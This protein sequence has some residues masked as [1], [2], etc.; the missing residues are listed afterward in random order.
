MN[1]QNK[2]N[3]QTALSLLFW[4]IFAAVAEPCFILMP[5]N[6]AY[7][8]EP[9]PSVP[10]FMLWVV[11]VMN[12]PKPIPTGLGL[13]GTGFL[14]GLAEPKLCWLLSLATQLPLT[15]GFLLVMVWGALRGQ[16]VSQTPIL[17]VRFH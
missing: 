13:L 17:I 4:T 7:P 3:Y 8:P 6:I 16:P 5:S 11:N 10:T 14:L 2:A 1:E 12:H 15:I 9:D